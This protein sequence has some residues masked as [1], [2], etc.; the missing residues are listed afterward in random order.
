M[1]VPTFKQKATSIVIIV[2]GQ[3]VKPTGFNGGVLGESETD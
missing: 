3:I 2:G 1:T